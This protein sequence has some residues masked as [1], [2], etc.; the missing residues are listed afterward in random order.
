MR[1]VNAMRLLIVD[2]D[3]TTCRGVQ[4]RI[5]NMDLWQIQDMH[6]A[7]SAEE[8]LSWAK[9]HPVDILLT[10]IQMVNMNGLELIERIKTLQPHVCSLILTAHPSFPYAQQA[11]ALGVIGFLLKPCGKDEMRAML[12]K[13]IAQAEASGAAEEQTLAKA[14]IAWAQDYV[15]EHL[16]Q[17]ID[18]VLVANRLDLSYTYF[19]KLF[20]QETG[21]SFSNYIV[22]EKMKEAGR[23][24][25]AGRRTRQI[26]LDLG[27][28]S[29]QN[30]NRTFVRYYQCTPGEYARRAAE[31]KKN[32]P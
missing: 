24:V 19:S 14:P 29:P 20:K 16:N 18:M 6:M 23:Q 9:D 32:E 11:I 7:F 5:Q 10:D 8:A 22:S 31:K 3:K 17:K 26:A 28:Q 2:D 4:L 21:Q 1:G 25:L 15:R 27:Y 12:L 13:A 30:F